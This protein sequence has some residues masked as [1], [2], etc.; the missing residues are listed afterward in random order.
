[1]KIEIETIQYRKARIWKMKERSLAKNRSEVWAI[2]HLRDAMENFLLRF[3][4]A[5]Y[6]EAMLVFL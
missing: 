3:K 5:L 1:M 2:F 6:R 4:T